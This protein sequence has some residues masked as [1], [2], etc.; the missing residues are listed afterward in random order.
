[1]T[2]PDA[3]DPSEVSYLAIDPGETSGFAQFDSAGEIKAYGQFPYRKEEDCL[4]RLIHE[5]LLAV[6]VE[7]YK[8]HPGMRQP[9]WSR[10]I[11]SKTIGKIELLCKMRSISLVL[12][13]NNV[14]P[15]GYL[16][17]GLEQPKNHSISHQFDAVAHGWYYLVKNK[18][19]TPDFSNLKDE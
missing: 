10:N 1:M 19:R 16:Y 8:N 18:I 11:T 13:P 3:A 5:G 6:I 15:M 9:T 14:R 2:L 4:Q 7:D 17:A 12:Q